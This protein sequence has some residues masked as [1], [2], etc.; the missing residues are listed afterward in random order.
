MA[1]EAAQPTSIVASPMRVRRFANRVDTMTT[2]SVLGSRCSALPCRCRGSSRT[3][4]IQTV[5]TTTFIRR[6]GSAGLATA[7]MPHDLLALPVA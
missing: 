5:A 3:T 4:I 6:H 1:A 2:R 7:L